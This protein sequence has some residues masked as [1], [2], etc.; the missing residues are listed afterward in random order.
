[1]TALLSRPSVALHVNECTLVVSGDVDLNAAAELAAVGV[2]WLENSELK[3]VAFNFSAVSKASSVAISVL[4][5][6]M[7]IC[8][9][10][11]MTIQSIVLSAPL[12]RLASLAELDEL[13]AC[14]SAIS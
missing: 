9:R 14:P 3:E 13:I 2:K 4:F 11:Q 1:M 7:R 10:R 8:N 5:E 6:W 12:Q